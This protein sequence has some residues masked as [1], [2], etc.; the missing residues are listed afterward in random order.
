MS[1]LLCG[2]DALDHPGLE[3]VLVTLVDVP[4]VSPETVRALMREWRTTGAPIVR[5]AQGER[6]GH[7]VLFDRRLFGELRA[8]DPRA[9]AKPVVHAHAHELVNLPVTDDGAFVDLDVPEDYE[10]VV[11]MVREQGAGSQESGIGSRGSV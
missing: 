4:L 7:P 2:L 9:G 1:T 10:R 3:A 6:H 8:A 11:R 5:P